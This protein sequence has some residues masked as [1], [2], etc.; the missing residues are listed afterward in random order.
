[1]ASG[2]LLDHDPGDLDP[3]RDFDFGV[4]HDHGER[5]ISIWTD[6]KVKLKSVLKK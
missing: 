5:A 3:D 4:D 6:A 1:M 2:D